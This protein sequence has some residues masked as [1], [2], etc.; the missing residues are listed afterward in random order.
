[1]RRRAVTRLARRTASVVLAAFVA[2]PPLTLTS[3]A[4]QSQPAERTIEGRVVLPGRTAPS[5]VGGALV[6]LHR[7]GADAAG[8][9]DSLRTRGDGTFR[10][11]Y[12]PSGDTSAVYF[13]STNRGGVAYFTAPLRQSA[14]RGADT[15]L[16]VYDTTSG[17]VRIAVQG[18]HI[19]LP[20]PDSAASQVRTVIEVYELSNDSTLTRVAGRDGGATFGAPLPPGV[21]RVTAGQGDISPDAVRVQDGRLHVDAPLAPG[22]KQLSFFYEVPLDALP[23]AYTLES[24]VPVLE[25]LIE[26]P[27]GT[28]S[29]AGMTSS[30]QLRLMLIVTAV[31]AAMLLGLGMAFMRKGPAALAR[32]RADDPESLALA[33]AALD[34][35]FE[36]LE[37]PTEAQRAEHYLARAQLKGRLSAALAKRDGLG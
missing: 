7:V 9:L 15:E 1:M 24:D 20:A 17:P 19:I 13:V 35:R 21:T 27:N 25:V 32:R 5:P 22:L 30:R 4:L 26:D 28:A 8:P 11:R 37:S 6:V 12:R 3:R 18:R 23:L 16:L 10:F 33:V 2:L 31:G 36:R 34:E 29:G 14:A